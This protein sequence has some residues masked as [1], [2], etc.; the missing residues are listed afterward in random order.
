MKPAGRARGRKDTADSSRALGRGSR[1]GA[2][3][4]WCWLWQP[5]A[6]SRHYPV[7]SIS[8]SAAADSPIGTS[9]SSES[10]G[11]DPAHREDLNSTYFFTH[12]RGSFCRA[13]IRDRRSS[14]YSW[15]IARNPE[16]TW[17]VRRSLMQ[18]ISSW[19]RMTCPLM[20]TLTNRAS[21]GNSSSKIMPSPIPSATAAITPSRLLI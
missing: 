16:M 1:V 12:R 15:A 20:G 2:A 14:T 13:A 3:L 8:S 21:G 4:L 5:C 7:Y 19:Q 10:S 18:T 17:L 11:L 6:R 9:E